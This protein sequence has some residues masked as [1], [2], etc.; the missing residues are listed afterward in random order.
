[1]WEYILYSIFFVIGTVLSDYLCSTVFESSRKV[2]QIVFEI[3]LFLIISNYLLF[4]T[5]VSENVLIVSFIYFFF[6]FISMIFS[7]VMGFLVFDRVLLKMGFVKN[8]NNKNAITLANKL[9]AKFSKREVI[10]YFN[11]SGFSKDLIEHLE[12]VLKE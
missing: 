5:K 9:M 11:S 2:R 12:K 8:D 7:R 10:N 3:I 1:M 6:S 4:N